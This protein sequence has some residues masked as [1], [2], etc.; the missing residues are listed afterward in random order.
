MAK[1]P[2]YQLYAQD[3]DMDT[4]SWANDEV[5]VYVRLL[6]YEWS[7]G[8]L[9]ADIEGLSRIAREK[10]SKFEKIW[11]KNL[12]KKFQENG[13][14][15]LI[16]R[17][18]EEVR[19]SQLKYSE[20]RRKNVSVRYQN[21]PTHEP[22]YEE[23]MNLHT[24]RSSSS[25]SSSNNKEE[26]IARSDKP[27]RAALLSD[28]DYIKSL[29]TNPAF[30]GI[31]IDKELSKLDAWLLTPRGKGK[32]KTRQR[33]FNWLCRAEKP[34]KQT[35]NPIPQAKSVTGIPAAVQQMVKDMTRDGW[36]V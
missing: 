36:K 14:G 4:A 2:A 24:A 26:K 23:D 25:S 7:N 17:R 1:P 15:F 29:K 30:E 5:G 32:L 12:S 18:M 19:Q 27:K 3:F 6:N 31:D 8:H 33:I 22:T 34:F 10:Q 20:S 16:N 13:G 21:K 35:Q 9:P 11:G 28:E